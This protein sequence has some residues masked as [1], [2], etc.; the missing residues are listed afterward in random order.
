MIDRNFKS[1]PHIQLSIFSYFF[2]ALTVCFVASKQ[3][4][5]IGDSW[6]TKGGKELQAVFKEHGATWEIAN[7]AQGG[8]TTADW[9]K[10]PDRMVDDINKNPDAEYVWL[11]LGGNDAADYLPGCTRKHPL[12]DEQ[13]INY[14]LNESISNIE[15]MLNPVFEQHPGIQV[16][17]F[18]YDIM[19]FQK[20]Y[21]SLEGQDVMHGCNDQAFCI[22]TQFTKIQQAVDFL[23]TK[24]A[25]Y[26]SINL[27]GYYN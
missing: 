15:I 9:A 26:T 18:G 4:V 12:P 20:G 11:T 7:Y 24:Y 3:V 27:L 23:A 14:V 17:Q 19:N 25:N 5:I 13:C 22:N 2:L 16:V 21:C 8:T 10:H 1:V 6:G